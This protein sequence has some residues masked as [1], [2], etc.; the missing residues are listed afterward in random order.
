MSFM[1]GHGFCVSCR[2]LMT[3][4]PNKVPSLRVEGK[5]EPVCRTCIEAAN[6]I[7]KAKGLPEIEIHPDAYEPEEVPY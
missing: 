1:L 2:Q 4:N 7:R 3:F 5:R 6:P